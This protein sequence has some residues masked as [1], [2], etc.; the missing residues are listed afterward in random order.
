VEVPLLIEHLKDDEDFSSYVYPDSRGYLT[1]GYGRMV[2]KRLGGGVSEPEGSYLL[3][4][5][6]NETLAE[7]DERLPWWRGLS[8]L[9]QRVVADMAF[10]LGLPKLLQF[11]RTLAAIQAGDRAGAARGMRDSAWFSQVGRRSRR[12]VIMMETG[13]DP[14]PQ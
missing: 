7:L 12:L 2:D 8:E 3:L 11:K 6:V 14:G 13:Y 5:D 9:D 10:N 1:I 4:N